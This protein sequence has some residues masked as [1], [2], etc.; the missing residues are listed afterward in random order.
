MTLDSAFQITFPGVSLVT[1]RPSCHLLCDRS[2]LEINADALPT[3]SLLLASF[4]SSPRAVQA[5]RALVR[6]APLPRPSLTALLQDKASVLGSRPGASFRDASL[7]RAGWGK[8]SV[9]G[10]RRS[11]CLLSWYE[12]SR[13]NGARSARGSALW[14]LQGCMC[15]RPGNSFKISQQCPGC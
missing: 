8:E 2:E 3:P 14:D 6:S 10:W 11:G 4:S 13:S 1:K 7:I 9:C 5:C 15:G 12:T